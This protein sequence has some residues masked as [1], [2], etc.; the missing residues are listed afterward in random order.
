[1][2]YGNDNFAQLELDSSTTTGRGVD[3]GLA[4]VNYEEVTNNNVNYKVYQIGN[5]HEIYIKDGF[6][7]FDNLEITQSNV[8]FDASQSALYTKFNQSL[9]K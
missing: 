1:M 5:A 8:N 3:I 7:S 4:S 9:N 6:N 2:Q